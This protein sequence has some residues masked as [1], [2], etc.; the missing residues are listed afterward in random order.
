MWTDSNATE[1]SYEDLYVTVLLD[2]L[3]LF[4]DALPKNAI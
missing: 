4:Q 3:C 1:E 2:E